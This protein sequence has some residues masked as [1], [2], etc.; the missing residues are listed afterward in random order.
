MRQ[1]EGI[2]IPFPTCFSKVQVLAQ[3]TAFRSLKTRL[4]NLRSINLPEDRSEGLTTPRTKD[5]EFARWWIAISE[6]EG[7]KWRQSRVEL[8]IVHR[9]ARSTSPTSDHTRLGSWAGRKRCGTER[10]SLPL[11][12]EM[13]PAHNNGCALPHRED[14]RC[15]PQ[16]NCRY[17]CGTY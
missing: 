11:K 10:A 3:A 7:N 5:E 14:K 12:K 1:R 16:W 9:I 13:C 4:R 15:G 2:S 8:L 17:C 6:R